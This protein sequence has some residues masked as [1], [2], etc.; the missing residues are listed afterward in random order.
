MEMVHFIPPGQRRLAMLAAQADTAPALISGASG[1][2]K[3]A[4]ARWIHSNSPR[5]AH[6]FV[7][8][9]RDRSF[10]S[11]V[12][13]AQGGTLVV[14]DIGEW[15]LGEQRAILN[16]LKSKSV[17]HAANPSMPMLLNVRLIATTDQ[18]LEGRAQ[19]GLF[20][21]ELLA[22]LNVFRIEMP[23][24]VRRMEEFEDITL[25]I[26]GEITRE[27]HKAYLR[28]IS[29]T[30]WEALRAYEWP[31]NLRELRNVL[32][33]AVVSARGDQIETHDLPAFGSDRIDFRATREQFEKI[34]LLELLRT[35]DWEVDRTCQM[36]RMDRT[37][38]LAKM[39]QYG[40]DPSQESAIPPL[41]PSP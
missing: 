10:V 34:Y 41:P 40:I 3:G 27:L 23:P 14:P 16:F 15:P 4:I 28:T 31:G 22:R 21:P 33:M 9:S 32:R 26:L 24:L 5:A 12:A 19:G 18:V 35:F 20:N 39:Q 1:T 25:G 6:P 8:A 29:P 2:G 37:T 7:N 36:A 17:P 11:Q 30:A 13:E 38:L